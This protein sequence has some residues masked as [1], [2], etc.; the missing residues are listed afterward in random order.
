[1]TLI[2]IILI[3]LAFASLIYISLPFFISTA[4]KERVNLVRILNREGASNNLIF[5]SQ[6]I[7]Q[8][9]V[10]GIDGIHRKI[11]ILEKNKNAFH[12]TI[13][14]LDEVHD[15]KLVTHSD[16][17]GSSNITNPNRGNLSLT[18]S[19]RFD[20]NKHIQPVSIIFSNGLINSKREFDLLRNKA[21]H[22][23]I[24]FSKMLNSPK[25]VRA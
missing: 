17:I 18:L 25:E 8:N 6:E 4:K 11:M 13:I 23:C 16:Q 10:I 24:M 20:F 22:W 9:K 1:M 14:L 3:L 15:C 12:S 5:C 7:L 21:E 19:L 2:P